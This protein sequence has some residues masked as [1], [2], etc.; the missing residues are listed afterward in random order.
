MNLIPPEVIITGI[1]AQ[2]KTFRSQDGNVFSILNIGVPKDHLLAGN[3]MAGP[4]GLHNIKVEE[5][6]TGP[7][8]MFG[9]LRRKRRY[10]RF[11]SKFYKKKKKKDKW[12]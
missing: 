1:R 8:P 5:G 2:T 6:I 10:G 11:P 3:T 9:F 7:F 4:S 12:K